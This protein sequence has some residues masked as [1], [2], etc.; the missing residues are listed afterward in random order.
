MQ[1]AYDVHL[2]FNGRDAALIQPIDAALCARGLNPWY[3]ERDIVGGDV[4]EVEECSIRSTPVCAIFLGSE[5]WGPFH[6]RY[7]RLALELGRPIVPILLPDCPRETLEAEDG[8]FHRLT[9]AWV[10]LRS[11]ED[12]AELNALAQRIVDAAYESPAAAGK[13]PNGPRLAEPEDRFSPARG[14][15]AAVRRLIAYVPARSQSPEDWQSLRTRLEAEPALAG[16]VWHA[17]RYKADAWSSD[18]MEKFALDL[19]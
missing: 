9:S 12:A 19:E 7:A 17:H 13:Q 2:I 6:A 14:P 1:P 15:T 3:W 4:T 8:L 18:G 5:G 16:A 11:V 10:R